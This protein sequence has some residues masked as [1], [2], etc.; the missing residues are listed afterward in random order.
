VRGTASSRANL[1]HGGL[2]SAPQSHTLG[3]LSA[4]HA[5][6]LG[7]Q[8]AATATAH[9][10]ALIFYALVTRPVEYDETLWAARN[11]QRLK[12]LEEK[13]KRQAKQLGYQLVPIERKARLR[14]S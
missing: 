12:R 6:P 13:I 5:V 1:P 8:A 4:P 3:T 9:K 14:K 7:P 2:F 11:A 10:I